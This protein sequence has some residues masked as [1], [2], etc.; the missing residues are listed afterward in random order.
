[1]NSAIKKNINILDCTLRDGGYYNNWNF[2]KDLIQNYIH[3]IS[4]TNIRYIELGFRFFQRNYSVGLTAYTNDKLI[5]SLTIPEKL[6]IGVMINV[7]ELTKTSSSPLNQLKKLFPT[8]NKKIKFVRFACH[9][10]E[11]F[12]LNDSISWLK[13]NK[14]EVFVNI[15]QSSEIK[16]K[17]IKK[18]SLFLKNKK[19]KALYIADSLGSLNPNSLV[20][21]IRSFEKYWK[22]PMGIHAHNNLNLALINSL[23]A[24]KNGFQWIDSTILGMGRG[25]GNLLTEDILKLIDNKNNSNINK[26]KIK[27]FKKLKK[28]YQWG[29]NKYYEI[30]AKKKIHPTYIQEMLSDERYGSKSYNNTITNLAK[31]D[32]KKYDPSKLFAPDNIYAGKP[33]GSWFP[34]N[35]LGQKNILII[36]PGKSAFRYKSK[37]EKFIKSNNLFVI[38]VNTTSSISENLINLRTVCHPKRIVADAS[39]HNKLRTNISMPR[40]MMPNQLK[41]FFKHDNKIIFD[42]GL[43]IHK[44]K[45][46]N[47][48][49]NFCASPKPLV[50]I[51]SLSIAVSGKAKKVF[52]AGFDGLKKDD[53][54]PS[55][56][57]T[58]FLINKFKNK[59]K[60]FLFRTITKTSHNIPFLKI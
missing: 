8:I 54:N 18:V 53:P 45:E 15:M 29:P 59:N 48:F 10:E 35:D 25:P 38:A 33:S 55:E 6:N 50:I 39:F 12:L 22:S 43:K 13:K 36:G 47:I 1:M 26:L 7:S 16:I 42:F 19:I 52:L 14:I 17:Q 57:E 20:K 49:K 4:K 5:N 37:I 27:Y 51:Y 40:S 2:S 60:K 11:V 28:K 23:T 21:I 34:Q 56:D 44:K 31:A 9:F 46:I 32:A 58:S 24:V 41:F 3:E 30:A